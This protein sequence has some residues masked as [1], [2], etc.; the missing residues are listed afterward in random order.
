MKKFATTAA[1][2]GALAAGALGFAAA[3]SAVPLGGAPAEDAIRTLQ[4]E[5]YM[6]RINQTVNVPLSRCIVTNVSG[7]RGSE[8]GG[9]LTV[10]LRSNI[11]FL[12]VDCTH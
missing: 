10:A 4:A 8:A 12:D 1:V 2:A 11:A 7:L 3:A 6:V 9:T 5:G